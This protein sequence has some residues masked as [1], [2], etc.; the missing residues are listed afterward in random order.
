MEGQYVQQYVSK[1]STVES[2]VHAGEGS[3]TSEGLC[4]AKQ[5]PGVYVSMVKYRCNWWVSKLKSGN[6][7]HGFNDVA[8]WQTLVCIIMNYD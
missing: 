2:I 3:P 6:A 4:K 1:N 7:V 8:L 5:V